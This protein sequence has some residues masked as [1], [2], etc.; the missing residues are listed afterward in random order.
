MSADHSATVLDEPPAQFLDEPKFTTIIEIS[1]GWSPLRLRQIW[2]YRE[3]LYFLTWR[4]IKIRYKQ[5]AF[6]ASWAVLQPVLTMI[7][8]T[9]VFGHFAKLP[10][11]GVPYPAFIYC[12]LLPWTFFSYAIGQS[13]NSIVG[14]ANLISKVYFPRL[15]IPIA[16]ILSGL[17]DFAIAFVVFLGMLL[18]YGLR[19]TAAIITLPVF[20]LLALAAA[21]AVGIWLS[22]LNVQYRDVRHTL[23][24]LTQIWLFATPIVYPSSLIRGPLHLVLALNPMAAA[25]EG[26]RWALLGKISLDGVSFALSSTVTV[27][28]LLGGL[29]YFRRMERYFADIV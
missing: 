25:V 12:G 29:Y 15:V 9:I 8:F 5:T 7:I 21:L 4:D 24:F 11:N 13:A 14:N 6:G 28:A 10:S 23:P 18:Y 2:P 26:F 16:A 1:R 19:P 27:I 3:L 22:A 17:L 20:F